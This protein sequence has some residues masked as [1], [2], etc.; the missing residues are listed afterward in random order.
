MSTATFPKPSPLPSLFACPSVNFLLGPFL[1]KKTWLALDLAVSL[2]SG[3]RWLGYLILPLPKGEPVPS[4]PHWATTRE[5]GGERRAQGISQ[6][7]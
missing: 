2:A 6:R 4:E 3:S 7:E 1:S 5:A